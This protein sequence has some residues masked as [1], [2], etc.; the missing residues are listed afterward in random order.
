MIRTE[1]ISY[2]INEKYLVQNITVE[3]SSQKIT[4]ISGPNGAGKTTLIH[5]LSG[6]YNPSEGN[7]WLGSSS[8]ANIS[9]KDRAKICGVLSQSVEL[10]FPLSVRNVVAMG[11]YPHCAGHLS[12]KDLDICKE[13]IHFFDIAAFADRNYLSLSGGE[14]QR[15]QFARVATQIWP[16]KNNSGDT[17]Y[18]LLDEPFT[19]LDIHYQLQ[20]IEHLREMMQQ[21]SMTVIGVIHDLNLAVRHADRA[22]LMSEGKMVATGNAADVYTRENIG[23]VFS[24]NPRR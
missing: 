15:V 22:V 11:R 14:K 8:L 13:A 19:H 9:Q 3:F 7:V 2:K 24:V 21:Q 23:S 1:N 18:L 6:R 20:F 12:S 17:K 16:D 5:L 10:A 4:L